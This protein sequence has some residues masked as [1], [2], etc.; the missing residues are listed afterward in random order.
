M[1]EI[2]KLKSLASNLMFDMADLEYETL[3]KEFEV[4]LKQMDLIAKIEDISDVEPMFHPFQVD[5]NLRE[6]ESDESAVSDIFSN[7]K[8]VEK[9]KISIPKV[10]Q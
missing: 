8:V 5:F 7:A 3:K 4:I 1:I 6:D 10:V 2:E 9:N